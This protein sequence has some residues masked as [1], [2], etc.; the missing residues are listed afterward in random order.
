MGAL[1]QWCKQCTEGYKG[2]SVTNFHY[3]WADGLAFCALIHAHR[4]ELIPFDSLESK[5]KEKNIELAFS[6]ATKLGIPQLLDVEDML[7]VSKPE[8]FSIMTYLSQFYHFFK[9]GNA[10]ASGLGTIKME[11]TTTQ[12]RPA[13]SSA[14]PARS[15]DVTSP[16]NKRVKVE[17]RP[18]CVKCGK[19]LCGNTVEAPGGMY[20]A[21]CFGCYKCGKKLDRCV[22]VENKP[23]CDTCGRAALTTVKKQSM[24]S[25]KMK[26][27]AGIVSAAANKSKWQLEREAREKRDQEAKERFLEEK[28][29]KERLAA[30]K[31]KQEA[32]ERERLQRER[33]EKER[34]EREKR[35]KE[36][37]ERQE[38]ERR[39][40]EDRERRD[41]ETRERQER[42]KRE[43]DRKEKDRLDKERREKETRDRQERERREREEREKRERQA[44]EEEE[45]KRREREEREKDR[46]DK[47]RR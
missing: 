15:T 27:A 40:R 23:Y 34:I 1:L 22:N 8:P 20:H 44:R 45:K 31:R 5:N 14:A 38:S 10:K 6:T 26:A 24:S 3:S 13:T 32:E 21:A 9:T 39:E 37:R 28:K 4:L 18:K 16:P 43:A 12:K 25:A 41:R 47:E 19:D 30:E 35:E 2:V 17:E 42:E 36:T 46:L 33:Q 7:I 29:E 11:P